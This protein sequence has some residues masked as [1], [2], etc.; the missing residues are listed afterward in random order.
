MIT[1]DDPVQAA[2][3]DAIFDVPVV[4][5]TTVL[6]EAEWVLR[7]R[8]YATRRDTTATLLE[9]IAETTTVTIEHEEGVRWAT[10]RYRLGADFADMIHLVVPADATRS[11]TF[12]RRLARHAGTDAP[13]AIETLA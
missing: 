13:L 4:I 9:Q 11:V 5:T 3:A 10:G 6:L 8:R 12:D 2:L 7:G 1:R